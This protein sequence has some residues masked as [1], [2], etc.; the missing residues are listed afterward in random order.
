MGSKYL[1]FIKRKEKKKKLIFPKGKCFRQLKYFLPTFLKFICK[2]SAFLCPWNN[3]V[4]R[5]SL[6]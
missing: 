1:S 2:Q 5:G 4:G 3:L 6:N